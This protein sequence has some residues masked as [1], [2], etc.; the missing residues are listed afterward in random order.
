VEM[1]VPL[2]GLIASRTFIA[3]VFFDVLFS[4]II[5]FD[6]NFNF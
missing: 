4:L 3:V 6:L 2:A 5:A 1:I